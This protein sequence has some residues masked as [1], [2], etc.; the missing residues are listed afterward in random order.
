M[1]LIDALQYKDK[2]Y[3]IPDCSRDDLPEFFRELGFTK[4]A[5]IGVAVGLN[6]LNYL[7]AGLEMIGVDPYEDYDDHIYRPLNFCGKMGYKVDTEEDVYNEAMKICSPYPNFTMIRKQSLEAAKE[8]EDNSLDFVYID[9]NHLYG[10]CAV[11]LQVWSRKVRKNGIIAG[12]DYY[13]PYGSRSCRGVPI[14][15]DGFVQAYD[16]PNFWVLG[17]KLVLDKWTKPE[18]ERLD[19]HLSFM[20]FKHW[21]TR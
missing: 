13:H 6:M 19:D 15:V 20:M 10:Y 7:K 1:R 3:Y 8:I 18:G 16:I 9:A 17:S 2:P 14:A 21:R 12:H 5:E 4:G 11:D